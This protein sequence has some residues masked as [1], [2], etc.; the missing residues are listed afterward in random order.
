MSFDK[1]NVRQ[2]VFEVFGA[3]L[4]TGVLTHSH[5][6]R[7]QR[8]TTISNGHDLTVMAY[9]LL[10]SVSARREYQGTLRHIDNC[11]QKV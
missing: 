6:Y 1:A 2:S 9:A 3:Y 5:V 8:F 11:M 10:L 7:Q 4:S